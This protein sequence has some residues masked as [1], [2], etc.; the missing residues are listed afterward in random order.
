MTWRVLTKWKI[1]MLLLCILQLVLKATSQSNNRNK[2][3]T[4]LLSNT[5]Q[6]QS[7]QKLT[8]ELL[9]ESQQVTTEL[10]LERQLEI[11]L[12]MHRGG[13]QERAIV[14][15]TTEHDV[16]VAYGT[17]A[18]LQCDCSY[19]GLIPHQTYMVWSTPRAKLADFSNHTESSKYVCK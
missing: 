8:Y 17:G 4:T 7:D 1:W 18:L 6:T 3:L 14:R 11:Q 13:R 12:A 15:V 9:R 2:I 5:S 16:K 19:H 10:E